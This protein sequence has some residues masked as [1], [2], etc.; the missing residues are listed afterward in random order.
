MR[1]PFLVLL[2]ILLF[3]AAAGA[4]WESPPY[5]ASAEKRA[6]ANDALKEVDDLLKQTS[7]ITGLPIKHPVKSALT[8]RDEIQKYIQG[9]LKE[10]L[11]PAK[12]HAQ[13]V[14]LKEFR[15]LPADFRLE[16]FMV[17]LLT[18]QA[19]AYYDP[20]RKQFFMADW[21]PTSMQRPAIVHELT[22]ALQDQQVSLTEYLEASSLNQD[23]QTARSAVVEGGG[24]LAMTDFLLSSMGIKR[25]ALPNMDKML[26]MASEAEMKQFPVFAAAPPYLREG[27]LFPYTAGMR[28]VSHLVEKHGKAGYV[29]AMKNPPHSTAEILHPERAPL[30]AADLRLP[31]IKVPA[32]Y[33]LLDE[34][35]LGEFDV[36][37]LLK[38]HGGE[39]DAAEIAAAWRGFRYAVYE[40]QAGSAAFLTHR[41]QWATDAAA[42]QFAA[43]FR[44]VLDAKGRKNAKV[45]VSGTTVTVIESPPAE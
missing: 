28:Y 2:T 44:K 43:A 20:K 25:S 9:R 16:E 6:A 14:A 36:Q 30:P 5:A 12:V 37:V 1:T 39:R 21:T 10:S 31:E 15:L 3:L 35:V 23:E 7:E 45:E 34:D 40:N 17:K 27:L 38:L 41:S 18:E 8:S 19:A 22:H 29:Y 4:A 13:E 24:A 42:R 11:T 32:G 33:K 26:A